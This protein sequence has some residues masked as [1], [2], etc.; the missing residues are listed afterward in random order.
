MHH[1]T[2]AGFGILRNTRNRDIP[3][4]WRTALISTSHYYVVEN[5]RKL[6]GLLKICTHANCHQYFGDRFA[7][8]ST[9][10]SRADKFSFYVTSDVTPGSYYVDN[11]SDRHQATTYINESKQNTK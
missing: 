6:F 11:F 8:I 4:K 1:S 7:V 5:D 2:V 10:Y 9:V 3:T